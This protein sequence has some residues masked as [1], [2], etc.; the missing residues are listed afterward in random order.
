MTSAFGAG[1]LTILRRPAPVA[2]SAD[3]EGVV[4]AAREPGTGPVLLLSRCAPTAAFSRRDTLLGG[5]EKAVSVARE[6]G[7]EPVI[8]PVGGRL[9]AYDGGALV[10]HLWGPHPDPR[11][12]LQQRFSTMAELIAEV[13]R[14]VGVPDVRVGPVPGEYCSGRWSVNSGG[15][16]KLV[17][18]GQR[19]FRT[20][21]LFSAVVSVG[22]TVCVA[23][24]LAE[25]YAALDLPL[26]PLAV[27]DVHRWA[28]DVD[29]PRIGEMIAGRLA[30]TICATP[31]RDAA[32]AR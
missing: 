24:L 10:L 2:G 31:G 6:A 14:D 3:L 9:A 29:V 20:G 26:D 28:S 4:A 12:D 23:R 27:G 11:R 7:F 30:R 22:P 25:A 32:V 19:L 16:T 21:F 13:L 8:R 18:T 17:G 15:R 5:Y 1:E